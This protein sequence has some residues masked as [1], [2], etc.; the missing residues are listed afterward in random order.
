M[1]I[2]DTQVLSARLADARA[3]IGSS[4]QRSQGPRL[5]AAHVTETVGSKDLIL[6][7]EAVIQADIKRILIVYLVLIGEIVVRE[8]GGIGGLRI[9][10][11]NVLAD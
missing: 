2:P 9:E 10:V 8:Y 3:T 7:A 1:R 6:L 4:P 11:G 5:L